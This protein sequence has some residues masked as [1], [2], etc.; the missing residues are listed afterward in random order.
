MRQLSRQLRICFGLKGSRSRLP[1]E[2]YRAYVP[3]EKAED[4]GVLAFCDWLQRV[5]KK[6]A[7]S[8]L[9]KPAGS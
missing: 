5:S 1:V 8:G 7:G 3:S 9:K 2:G 6:G 4:P